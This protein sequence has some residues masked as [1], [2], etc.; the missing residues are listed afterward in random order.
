MRAS[1][2][3]LSPV[4]LS[5]VLGQDGLRLSQEPPVPSSQ[6]QA[7]M[8]AA[9]KRHLKELSKALETCRNTVQVGRCADCRLFRDVWGGG[10][11]GA[12]RGGS[13]TSRVEPPPVS[14][15][16]GRGGVCFVVSHPWWWLVDARGAGD[17]KRLPCQCI[18]ITVLPCLIIAV[19]EFDFN[20]LW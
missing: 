5:Q 7:E 14:F 18:F 1:T 9:A 15:F 4:R 16:G 6:E 19:Y 2:E 11:G 13:R 8:V 10:W 3:L 12:G 20:S 17:T